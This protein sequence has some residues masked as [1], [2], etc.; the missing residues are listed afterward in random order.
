VPALGDQTASLVSLEVKAGYF[1]GKVQHGT[2]SGD[3]YLIGKHLEESRELF[4]DVVGV[5]SDLID[6]LFQVLRHVEHRTGRV[7]SPDQKAMPPTPPRPSVAATTELPLPSQ[8]GTA[9]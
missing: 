2:K 1:H 4:V 3:R 6:E 8:N 7:F 9:L 5:E